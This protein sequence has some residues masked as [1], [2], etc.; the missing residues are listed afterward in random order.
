[1]RDFRG[2]GIPA[3][4]GLYALPAQ[5]F[6]YQHVFSGVTYTVA[7]RHG[8]RGWVLIDHGT[9][10]STVA[11]SAIT[12]VQGLPTSG[13]VLFGA[14]DVT[15]AAA[16][17]ITADGIELYGMGFATV[18]RA[19][20]NTNIIKVDGNA[21]RRYRIVIADMHL[22]HAGVAGTGD[23]IEIENGNYITI[24]NV[25]FRVAPQD[26]IHVY[27]SGGLDADN[28]TISKCY[29]MQALTNEIHFNGAENWVIANNDFYNAGGATTRIIFFEGA[30]FWNVITGNTA[31]EYQI[32]IYLTGTGGYQAITG[33][34]LQIT[35]GGGYAIYSA[36]SQG[37]DAISGNN[38][39]ATGGT[40]IY[41]GATYNDAITG[42][43]ISSSTTGIYL[44]T[45]SH[46]LIEGNRVRG[47]TTGI[48]VSNGSNNMVLWNNL[49]DNTTAFADTGTNT[50]LPTLVVPFV[51]GTDPQDGG[52]LI[53]AAGEMARTYMQ[54]PPHVVQV[55]RAKVYARSAVAEADKMLVDL[56]CFG[57][58]DNEPYNTH[59]GS[60]ASALNFSANFAA[61]DVIY[62][63]LASAGLIALV[64]GDSVEF[65]VLYRVAAGANIDTQAYIRTLSIEY[66]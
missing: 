63:V 59:D 27:V 66:V 26:A 13:R 17:T 37:Y 40:A 36:E 29:F 3:D 57:A 38:L 56:I 45:S 25:R 24:E 60:L 28:G 4:E 22:W 20:N 2:E 61:D 10:F 42:N 15:V 16:L 18:M 48:N 51:D 39:R 5:A 53:N 12:Y 11:Q 50:L 65:K 34:T 1:M 21:A 8:A 44:T 54:L 41:L 32:G 55:V 43:V 30:C 52:F 7:V 64:G 49:R 31:E 19:G 47:C 58:A 35:V 14:F 33:N 9:V 23:C 62:W 46:H 6:V